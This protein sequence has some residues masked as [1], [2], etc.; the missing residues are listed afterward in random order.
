MV[1][2][3]LASSSKLDKTGGTL[4]GPLVLSR[5]PL[6]D[7]EAATR[8][9]VLAHAG[10]VQLGG[11]IGGTLTSPQIVSTH[12][13]APLPLA[14]GGTNAADAPGARAQLGLGTAATQ[15]SAAFDTAGSAASALAAA[16]A[17]AAATY[18][19]LATA[20]TKGDLLA[21]TGA[22][23]SR[24]WVW[25]LT[26]ECSPPRPGKRAAYSGRP[27]RAVCRRTAVRVATWP[28]PT[29]PRRWLRPRT[30]RTSSARTGST[31]SRCP[32]QPCP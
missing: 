26:A 1:S 5:D 2:I 28:A 22:G 17:N 16:E 18:L 14:Q 9:F 25:A 15:N 3:S 24:A 31:S 13:A 30:S 8:Q 19:P 11:D 20:T 7:L 29:R 4:T 6:L 23:A 27:C 21:A 10:G 32:P 12:L